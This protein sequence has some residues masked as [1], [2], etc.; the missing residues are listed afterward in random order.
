MCWLDY[1]G[2][3][4]SLTTVYHHHPT[5]KQHHKSS[6]NSISRALSPALDVGMDQKL[7]GI[8]LYM[9]LIILTG[10]MRWAEGVLGEGNIIIN[11]EET[12]G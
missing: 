3:V 6:L 10:V 2:K 12:G 9:V 7:Y 4:E 8:T 11:E 5:I 1:T